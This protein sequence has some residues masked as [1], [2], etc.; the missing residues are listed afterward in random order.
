MIELLLLLLPAV[1]WLAVAIPFGTPGPGRGTRALK[2]FFFGMVA[3]PL[4]FFTQHLVLQGRYVSE[5]PFIAG[6]LMVMF[7]VGPSEELWKAIVVRL[8]FAKKTGFPSEGEALMA[9]MAA[10][11]GYTI[12]EHAF[13]RHGVP[14]FILAIKATFGVALHA[15]SSPLWSL[16]MAG[17]EGRIHEWSWIRGALVAALAHGVYDAGAFMPSWSESPIWI[18]LFVQV[19]IVLALLQLF[20][21][22][23]PPRSKPLDENAVKPGN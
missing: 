2:A 10:A 12:I 14:V 7:V 8:G 4:A 13:V 22:R 3:F 21:M 5:L 11:V 16:R 17:V 18:A 1:F 15:L 9:G 20:F 23:M 19:T 6:I